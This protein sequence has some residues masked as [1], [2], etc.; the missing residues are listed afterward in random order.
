MRAKPSH[1][2]R[3]AP[4]MRPRPPRRYRHQRDLFEQDGRLASILWPVCNG[5]KPVPFWSRQ[6]KALVIGGKQVPCKNC[7]GTSG[8]PAP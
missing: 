3:W 6:G 4:L 7:H 1:Q 2:L 5:K 8:A